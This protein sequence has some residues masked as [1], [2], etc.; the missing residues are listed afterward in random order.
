MQKFERQRHMN[1]NTYRKTNGFF[2]NKE[3]RKSY[4]WFLVGDAAAYF[5][6]FYFIGYALGAGLVFYVLFWPLIKA[7]Y[8]P[9]F[10]L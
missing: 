3:S 9:L 2:K 8:G 4:F 5:M 6:I 10:G 1:F 7:F